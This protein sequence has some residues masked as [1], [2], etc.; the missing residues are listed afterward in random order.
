LKTIYVITFVAL[1]AIVSG[2]VAITPAAFADHAEVTVSPAPGSSSQG[3]ETSADGCFI[4][5]EATVDVGGSVIFSN[6]D[7]AA[8]TFTAGTAA[9]G[10]SGVFDSSLV[11]TGNSYEWKATTAGSFPYY[12]QVHPW[13]TG[14]IVVQ[15]AGH[16]DMITD[17][18]MKNNTMSNDDKTM[19]DNMAEHMSSPRK[20]VKMGV[21]V[22]KVQCKSGH[23]LVFKSTNWS[24]TCVKSTSV[25]KLIKIGW[26]SNHIPEHEMKDSMTDGTN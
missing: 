24:P 2:I 7:T 18:H 10:P 22:H 8:H 14:L 25:E 19:K 12:C 16:D 20:Q 26:A 13:M 17:D 9:D 15:E 11:I 4:P 1:F 5:K 21:D 6:T 23:E 3:C